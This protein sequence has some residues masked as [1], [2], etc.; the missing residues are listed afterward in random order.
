VH[1]AILAFDLIADGAAFRAAS[2][3]ARTGAS[4]RSANRWDSIAAGDLAHVDR[5]AEA[6]AFAPS[7]R[8]REPTSKRC[9]GRT[10]I[11]VA[12][13][14]HGRQSLAVRRVSCTSKRLGF[15]SLVPSLQVLV[16]GML[17]PMS[18]EIARA[19]DARRRQARLLAS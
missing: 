2:C 5:T 1:D 18:S 12:T 19:E 8:T 14:F 16:C 13:E 17:F 11:V 15:E 10:S 7:Q 6:I 3:A 9:A 4:P